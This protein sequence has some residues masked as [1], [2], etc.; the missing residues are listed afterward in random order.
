M[1]EHP[2]QFG[3][4]F[5]Y[6]KRVLIRAPS[7]VTKEIEHF[8]CAQSHARAFSQIIVVQT[9]VSLKVLIRLCH[10]EGDLRR[11]P[12]A[13]RLGHLST[14]LSP[15]VT[16]LAIKGQG[17]NTL[18]HSAPLAF[19]DQGSPSRHREL[20][21]YETFS[22]RMSNRF[23]LMDLAHVHNLEPPLSSF[24]RESICV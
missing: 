6:S 23:S 18:F 7:R 17:D 9:G 14:S 12:I 5:P 2:D 22:G 11:G 4:A 19:A 20:D 8:S 10:M 3:S 15:L 21:C 16:Q 24:T 13:L 1:V